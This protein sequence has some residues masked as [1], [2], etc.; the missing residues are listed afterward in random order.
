VEVK[1]G[2]INYSPYFPVSSNCVLYHAYWDQNAVDHSGHGNDGTVIGPTFVPTGLSFAGTSDER[3]ILP[4]SDSLVIGTGDWAV[5]V[6]VKAEKNPPFAYYCI[7]Q[8]YAMSTSAMIMVLGTSNDDETIGFAG[9]INIPMGEHYYNNIHILGAL[10]HI[11]PGTWIFLGY[12]IDR[13]VGG[14]IYINNVKQSDSFGALYPTSLG[15]WTKN[16]IGYAD[17][18]WYTNPFKGI[19]GEIYAFNAIPDRTALYNA[20]KTRYIP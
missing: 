13:D 17:G 16:R 4:T 5:Y 3:V 10:G 18:D 2:S 1:G 9:E 15:G 20:T 8:Q 6:W 19:I 7:M 11:V 14:D 12:E